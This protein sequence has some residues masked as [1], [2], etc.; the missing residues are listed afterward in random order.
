MRSFNVLLPLVGSVVIIALLAITWCKIA[1]RLGYAS[2]TGLL[3][4]IPVLNLGV[5]L[6]WAFS[7][8]PNEQIIRSLKSQSHRGQDER[9]LSFMAELPDDQ[10]LD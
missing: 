2:L 1:K 10:K 4:L 6:Y 5:L 8:S 7:E 9:G 3:M